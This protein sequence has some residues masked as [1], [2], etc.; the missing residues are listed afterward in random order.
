MY[1]HLRFSKY[2]LQNDYIYDPAFRYKLPGMDSVYM[3]LLKVTSC[4]RKDSIFVK[5][6]HVFSH[7]VST[8]QTDCKEVYF[9]SMGTK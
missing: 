8:K 2:E 6:E 7:C 4:V 5:L 1:L 3:S 9:Q